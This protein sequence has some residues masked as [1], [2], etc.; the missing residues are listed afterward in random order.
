MKIVQQQ[1]GYILILLRIE[2]LRTDALPDRSTYN[3]NYMSCNDFQNV[4]CN[5][6]GGHLGIR[7]LRPPQIPPLTFPELV[8]T[9][10]IPPSRVWI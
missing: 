8:R 10:L 6:M 1:K 7:A 2:F 4:F 3:I 5:G 9:D